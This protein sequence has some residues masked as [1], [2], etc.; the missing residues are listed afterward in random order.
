[1]PDIL[2]LGGSGF[3]GRRLTEMLKHNGYSVS[4]VTRNAEKTA[5]DNSAVDKVYGYPEKGDL[6]PEEYFEDVYG[7]INLAGDSIFGVRWTKEKKNRILRSR[8]DTTKLLADSLKY[9]NKIIPVI[10]NASAYGYYGDSKTPVNENSPRGVG[11]LADVCKA[12]EAEALKAENNTNRLVLARFAIILGDGGFIKVIDKS[13]VLGLAGRF[14]KGDFYLP[15]V[16]INDAAGALLY[17]LNDERFSGPVNIA[18]KNPVL[19]REFY[20]EYVKSRKA[21]LIISFPE[22]AAKIIFG[23][24]SELILSGVCIE[25]LKLKNYGYNYKYNNIREIIHDMIG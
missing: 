20:S 22:L 6:F 7:I 14:G 11:F 2:I 8:I 21:L 12:W 23:E 9:Y 1:M 16:H 25:P 10:I 19:F 15:Y 18:A 13:I 5:K 3:L 17:I 4:I 24:M